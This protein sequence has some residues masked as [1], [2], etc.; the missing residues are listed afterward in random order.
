[1]YKSVGENK[2]FRSVTLNIIFTS[3]FQSTEEAAY[4]IRG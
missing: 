1:M 3:P 4:Y 2:Q